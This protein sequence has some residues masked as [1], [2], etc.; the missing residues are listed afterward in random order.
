MG[1]TRAPNL[2]GVGGATVN[3]WL[4]SGWMPL[5]EPTAQP[6]RKPNIFTPDETAAIVGYIDSLGPSAYPG[7]PYNIDLSNADVAAGFR[8]DG[9][10]AIVNSSR[11]I[12]ACFAPGEPRWEAAVEEA[13]RKARAAL[14]AVVPAAF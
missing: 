9:L 4:T 8:A 3:L 10:G 1:S 12:T 11:G 13:T 2:V 5:K 7:V 14:G 6:Q